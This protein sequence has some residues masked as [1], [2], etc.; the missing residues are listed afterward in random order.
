MN[1]DIILSIMGGLAIVAAGWGA[2]RGSAWKRI[3]DLEDRMDRLESDLTGE[4]DYSRMLVD[5]IYRGLPPPPPAR[6][7]RS[8]A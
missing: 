5:H 2:A 4:R 8:E 7:V 6:P 3:K 1:P